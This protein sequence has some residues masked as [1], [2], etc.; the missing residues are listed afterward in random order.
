MTTKTAT[1]DTKQLPEVARKGASQA[2]RRLD[3]RKVKKGAANGHK[4][5]A[6][7]KKTGGNGRKTALAKAA[8]RTLRADFG[9]GLAT[10]AKM[11]G[12]PPTVLTRWEQ[13]KAVRLPGEAVGRVGR[14]G[15]ILEGL[16]RVMRRRF[17]P[18]W[19]EQPNDACKEIGARTPL[20]IFA[21]G[22]CETL[23]DMVWYLESGA[24]T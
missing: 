22:D 24:P 14:V 17:I 2:T 18:T 4:K 19:I 6:R 7:P 13:G 20:D 5:V 3:R 10:F 12:V 23:E 15:R 1:A 11:T 9:L 8:P 16:A 21:S